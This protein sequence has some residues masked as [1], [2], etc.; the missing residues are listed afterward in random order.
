MW[1][2]KLKSRRRLLTKVIIVLLN[3]LMVMGIYG[4][5]CE[6]ETGQNNIIL[7]IEESRGDGK[8][9]SHLLSTNSIINSIKRNFFSTFD[10]I[11]VLLGPREGLHKLMQL[12]L[13]LLLHLKSTYK[14]AISSFL[15]CSHSLLYQHQRRVLS[16]TKKGGKYEKYRRG[17]LIFT[18]WAE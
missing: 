9:S 8:L 12:K 7:D 10:S 5:L 6:T 3:Q 4:K 11:V 15:A 2:W 18:T 13:L 1:H 17:Y 14:F 16:M